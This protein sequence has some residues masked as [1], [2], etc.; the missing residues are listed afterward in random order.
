MTDGNLVLSQRKRTGEIV[1]TINR[2]QGVARETKERRLR[3]RRVVERLVVGVQV[4]WDVERGLGASDTSDVI[5]VRMRQ[6]NA[7]DVESRAIDERQQ[8]VHFVAWIDDDRT[9][10]G[11]ASD[12]ISVLVEG[13][14]GVGLNQHC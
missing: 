8:P 4:D 11:V 2:R 10:S 9:A 1:A 3:G 6:Q 7:L 5:D 14:T 12:D 13:R